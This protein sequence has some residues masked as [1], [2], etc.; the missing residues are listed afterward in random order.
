VAP[1]GPDEQPRRK[2]SW[3]RARKRKA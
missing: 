1:L 3:S 2:F